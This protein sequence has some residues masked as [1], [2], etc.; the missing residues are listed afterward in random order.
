MNQVIL[1][2]NAPSPVG[3]NRIAYHFALVRRFVG[4]RRTVVLR[5]DFDLLRNRAG[6]RLNSRL[7]ARLKA[8]SDS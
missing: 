2:G 1:P 8:G 7:N 3:G 4:S 5:A 6:G